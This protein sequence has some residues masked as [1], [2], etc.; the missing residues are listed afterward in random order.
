MQTIR[1]GSRKSRLAVIQTEAVAERI[2]AGH[3]DVL[4]QLV[5]M[6]T[7]GDKDQ[8]KCLDSVEGKGFFTQELEDSLRKGTIDL[9]VH[10][11]KDMALELPDDLPILAFSSRE[12]PRDV[13]VL[14]G[15]GSTVHPGVLP[16]MNR[17]KTGCSSARRSFQLL[18]LYPD[19]TIAPIR[20][21]VPTRLEK[22]DRGEYDAL[23]L[24]AAGLNR[25][26]LGSRISYFFPVS[27]MLPAAGQGILAIQGRRDF[28]SSLLTSLDD[29][30]SRTAALAERLIIRNLNGG[31]SLPSAAYCEVSGSEVRIRALYCVPENN[32][33]AVKSL[34]GNRCDS[35][36]I[37]LQLSNELRSEVNGL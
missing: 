23:V 16:D 13:L 33:F 2:R 31:C 6:D 1:I 17:L 35:L 27:E 15:K 5:T 32:R 22:L 21:N 3:P 18:R 37:A 25:L 14:P 29:P 34:A 10:S 8:Q 9:C 20:G 26:N 7:A 30:D 12:D 28:D 24:A 19:S 4:V 11:L 36:N